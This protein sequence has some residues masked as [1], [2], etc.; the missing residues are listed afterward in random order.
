ML[1]CTNEPKS[2][3]QS[4]RYIGERNG[5]G[6]L[7]LIDY[8]P[9]YGKTWWVWEVD[10]CGGVQGII[11]TCKATGARG[12][13]VKAFDGVNTWPQWE[14]SVYTLKAA[15]LVVGAWGYVYP[16]NIDQT[17]QAALAALEKADYLII[18]AESEFETSGTAAHQ[19][20]DLIRAKVPDA[21]IGLTTF[22]LPELHSSFPYSTFLVWTD[23]IAPQVYWADAQMGAADMLNQSLDQLQ[24][25]SKKPIY[26]VAQGY[27]QALPSEMAEFGATAV[28]RWVGGLSFWDIQSTTQDI[29]DSVKLVE[30]YRPKQGV[31]NPV[32]K[33]W[34]TSE[35]NAAL[36]SAIKTLEGY[37]K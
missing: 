8:S 11:N 5:W 33:M 30:T 4:S 36:D 34:T 1:L 25:L 35:F 18:D 12:A 14:Q 15:G 32:D 2:E 9:L 23:F 31:H 24:K 17:A 16:A 19:L 20:G 26:P 21:L 28:N 3:L 22:A 10:K 27:P 37:K 7:K 6:M 13:V 29:K